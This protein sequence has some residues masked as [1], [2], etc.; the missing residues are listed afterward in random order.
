[1]AKFR[2]RARIIRTVGDQ[3]ISGPEAAMIELVKN[4]YDADSP[5]VHISITPASSIGED[6]QIVVTD[7]GHGMSGIDLVEKWLEP[8]T[9]EKK[10]A[11]TSPNSRRMLGAK[12][13]GRFATARLGQ[14]LNV[15][16]L[17]STGE[18]QEVS[19]L[20]I[21]WDLFSQTKYLDEVDIEVTTRVEDRV[22]SRST[23]V[24]LE[25]NGLRDQWTEKQLKIL[26]RELRR[27]I[28]PL[29][30][31]TDEFKIFLDL[32]A[33]QKEKSGFDG[34]TLVSGYFAPIDSSSPT[35]H[36]YEI[37]PFNIE[38]I[39]HYMVSGVF[40]DNGEFNGIFVN[41]RGDAQEQSLALPSTKLDLEEVSCGP[42]TL[43]LNIYDREGS[44]ITE[45]FEA[46]NV[47]GIGRIEAKKIL[48][49]NVGIG[50]YRDGFRIRPYGDA[51]NDWLEL[52]RMRVQNPSKKLGLN[53]V[54]GMVEVAPE[55]LS[56]LLERSSR[57]GFEHNGS[58]VRLK[59]L[60][61]DLLTHVEAIRQDFRQTAGISRKSEGDVFEVRKN[62]DF[63]STQKALD[64][65]PK[66]YQE[67]LK[68]AIEKDTIALKTSIAD[69][70]T[71]QQV[72]ASHST[73]GLVVG[74]VLHDGRRFLSD[75]TTR[76][77]RISEGAPRLEEDSAF[78][79]HFRGIFEKEAS[80]INSSAAQLSKL[81]KSLDPI[82]G[83]KRGRPRAFHIK[84][85]IDR[86]LGLFSDA[87]QSGSVEVNID[88]TGAAAKVYGYEADLMAALL[89]IIDNA[90]HWLGKCQGVAPQINIV[91]TEAGKYIQLLVS[92]NGPTI[93]E[94]FHESLFKPSFTLKA[95]GSGI[96]LAIAREAMR[97][98]KGDLAFDSEK[99]ETTFVI[100][101]LKEPQ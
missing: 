26:I 40:D 66:R 90:V 38:P 92:N 71:Y 43:R 4:A 19:E 100:E 85:V 52:E 55:D 50:I 67:K 93:A 9:D 69:L 77:K 60:I 72:L 37:R 34:Q 11:R 31:Q 10:K 13:V 75:I 51:E 25:I 16:T 63:N 56:N 70:E 61:S 68:R 65:L 83:K 30:A 41:R 42:I 64:K 15:S 88:L 59:R 91:A 28:S 32:S 18:Q 46:M 87:I 44:A 7:L 8:A 53:Q 82:S 17:K 47:E 1:M 49:E 80:S 99:E 89:N 48:D 39:F 2:P 79:R 5:S 36:P 29:R 3:L 20:S 14:R 62:A 97:A 23:G 101:M 35:V 78:G 54:W 81:F 33:F 95:E 22:L 12:G 27:L 86:S 6:G 58:F 21:D 45:L 98:S 96:G 94:R 57:E 73:L 74:Q 84:D 24:R 76:S